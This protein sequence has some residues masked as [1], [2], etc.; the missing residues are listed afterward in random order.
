MMMTG[1]VD[2]SGI[3]ED[4]YKIDRLNI[5]EKWLYCSLFKDK[6]FYQPYRENGPDS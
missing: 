1:P 5:P 2:D 6:P 4:Y 3:L